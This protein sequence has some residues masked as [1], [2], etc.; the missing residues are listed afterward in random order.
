[1]SKWTE[2][3]AGDYGLC[4]EDDASPRLSECV[5]TLSDVFTMRMFT[6]T[7]VIFLL[8]DGE[9]VRVPT[10]DMNDRMIALGLLPDY[11]RAAFTIALTVKGRM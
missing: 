4:F 3:R 8:A 11:A 2:V 7:V 9:Q 5:V 10:R 6:D 1:M